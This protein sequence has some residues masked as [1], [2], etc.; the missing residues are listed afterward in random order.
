MKKTISIVIIF[1]LITVI[2][3][4]LVLRI[5]VNTIRRD[6]LID[7]FFSV[8]G[9]YRYDALFVVPSE[10][11]SER[12]E[13]ITITCREIRRL[14]NG[15]IYNL[16]IDSDEALPGR[17][18]GDWDRFDLGYYYV[19]DDSVLLVRGVDIKRI[20]EE[21][22][23]DL[24][25]IVCQ[26]ESIQDSHS[27]I[28]QCEHEYID[29]KGSRSVFCYYDSSVETGYYEIQVWE[30]NKGLIHY[31]SGWGAMRDHMELTMEGLEFSL[32]IPNER[33]RPAVFIILKERQKRETVYR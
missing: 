4:L 6:Y 28:E 18:Y 16:C 25:T 23:I 14:K 33:I 2:I 31:M 24:G 22:L 29:N 32:D 27:E 8:D 12:K 1:G 20:S 9:D 15:I 13:R 3:S 5:K 26:K 30:K 11:T 21:E 7:Y 10:E 17:H 19:N